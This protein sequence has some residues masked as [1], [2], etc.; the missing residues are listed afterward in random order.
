VVHGFI[1]NKK[2]PIKKSHIAKVEA[3]LVWT[4]I[5]YQLNYV[6]L[7]SLFFH[8]IKLGMFSRIFP[9]FLHLDIIWNNCTHW[10][11]HNCDHTNVKDLRITLAKL[12]LQFFSNL[13][14]TTR[15]D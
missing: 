14:W 12:S 1:G 8:T 2:N 3:S 15:N 13:Q 10:H 6:A 4:F 7:T 5:L 11:F 9:S